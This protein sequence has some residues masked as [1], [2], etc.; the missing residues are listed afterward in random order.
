M[1]TFLEITNKIKQ[2]IES[3]H[4]LK[5]SKSIIQGKAPQRIPIVPAAAFNF[6]LSIIP[7]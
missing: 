1:S 5:T 2:F 6:I 7:S 4:A 3:F